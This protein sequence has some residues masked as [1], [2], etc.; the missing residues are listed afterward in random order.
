MNQR[1]KING[2]LIVVV[3]LLSIFASSICASSQSIDFVECK[4]QIADAK[5]V[6]SKI[7]VLA[8]NQT[9]SILD[10]YIFISYAEK[11]CELIWLIMTY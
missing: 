6:Y 7:Y 9:C 10:I 8:S 11:M 5:D 4:D 1:F 3:G 2:L